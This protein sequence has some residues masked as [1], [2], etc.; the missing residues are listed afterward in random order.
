M[1]DCQDT[2]DAEGSGQWAAAYAPTPDDLAALAE[3]AVADIPAPL[4]AHLGDIVFRVAE[5][6]EEAVMAELGL[7]SPFDLLGLYHGVSLAEK[8]HFESGGLPDSITLYRR[9]ILDVWAE[10]TESLGHLVRHVLIHEVG[11]HFGLSDADMAALE[12]QAED[13]AAG[14][15]DG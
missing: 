13:E 12:A 2:P 8:S 9:P 15:G 4:R 1:S 6:P 11:H 5:F 7:E 3:A 10:G 14:S